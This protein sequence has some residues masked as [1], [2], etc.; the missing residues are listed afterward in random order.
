MTL[1]MIYKPEI[2]LFFNNQS[3]R[4]Q[5]TAWQDHDHNT[6]TKM[7]G[8]AVAVGEGVGLAGGEERGEVLPGEDES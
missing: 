5:Q 1:L 3:R 7:D 8:Q 2:N 4:K 6:S